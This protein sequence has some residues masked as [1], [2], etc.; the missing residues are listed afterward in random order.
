M[1]ATCCG[2]PTEQPPAQLHSGGYNL[3]RTATRKLGARLMITWFC[4][5]AVVASYAAALALARTT[6]NE[7]DCAHTCKLPFRTDNGTVLLVG[8]SISAGYFPDVAGILDGRAPAA[9][10]YDAG[11]TGGLSSI[12]GVI[13]GRFGQGDGW[14]GTSYGVLQCVD[15]YLAAL[16]ANISVVHFNWGLHDI[17]PHIY[18][19]HVSLAQYY[20]N[21]E[22]LYLTFKRA[23]APGGTVVFATTTP[24]PPSYTR[25]RDNKD[26]IAINDMAKTLFGPDGKYPE[27]LINDLYQHAVDVCKN[28]PETACYPD[29]CDCT[30]IQDDGVHF[31]PAGRRYNALMVASSV[32]PVAAGVTAR[33]DRVAPKTRAVAKWRPWELAFF[34]QLGFIGGIFVLCSGMLVAR[35][36]LMTRPVDLPAPAA[37]P[38]GGETKETA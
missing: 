12:A 8:D 9:S 15:G 35:R 33:G 24:V 10:C 18:R 34:I 25:G 2:R 29:T 1:A 19:T 26:V 17:C 7:E 21:M 4:C 14:C 11:H 37:A 3:T 38:D 16:D 36:A 22:K 20:A 30:H 28:D 5:G 27:V 31:S 23:M 13:L 32:A 6:E